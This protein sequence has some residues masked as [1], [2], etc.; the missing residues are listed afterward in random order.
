MND[1]GSFAWQIHVTGESVTVTLESPIHHSDTVSVISSKAMLD[2]VAAENE[3]LNPLTRVKHPEEEKRLA[4]ERE[5]LKKEKQRDQQYLEA[6]REEKRM[7]GES[8]TENP[9]ALQKCCAARMN[10]VHCSPLHDRS[11]LFT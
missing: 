10:H 1:D 6:Y 4:R 8:S 9:Y 5:R 2:Q 11:V 7:Q 3:T